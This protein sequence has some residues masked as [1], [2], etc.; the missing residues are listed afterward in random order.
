MNEKQYSSDYIHDRAAYILSKKLLLNDSAVT[1]VFGKLS[2]L[3]LAQHRLSCTSHEINITWP[4]ATYI[5][6]II[7]IVWLRKV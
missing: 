3:L 7:F 4:A 5:T 1:I 6:V 2:D